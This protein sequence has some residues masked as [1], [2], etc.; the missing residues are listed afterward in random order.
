MPPP[1]SWDKLQKGETVPSE[2]LYPYERVF[3]SDGLRYE[4]R[5]F[6]EF[7]RAV[8]ESKLKVQPLARTILSTFSPD[9]RRSIIGAITDF[10]KLSPEEWGKG[11]AVQIDD[12]EYLI[13]LPNAMKAF[14][15]ILDSGQIELTD[16]LREETIRIF[17]Q[18]YA[19]AGVT[20]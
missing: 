8:L 1:E 6:G 14:V 7:D 19:K 4:W 17:L 9:S 5:P 11:K 12:F 18:K 13:Q 15:R 3:T 16:I 2:P 10:Q 20:R